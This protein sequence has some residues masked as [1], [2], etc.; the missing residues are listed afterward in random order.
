MQ[1]VIKLYDKPYFTVSSSNDTYGFTISS[2]LS[3]ESF[4]VCTNVMVPL[5]VEVLSMSYIALRVMQHR[6][7]DCQIAQ[8]VFS[9]PFILNFDG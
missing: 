8:R 6:Q 7:V 3:L 9:F 1:T 5:L 4:L 2:I